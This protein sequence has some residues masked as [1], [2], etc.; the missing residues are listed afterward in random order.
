[1]NNI[2][3]NLMMKNSIKM[4]Y[5]FETIES[6]TKVNWWKYESRINGIN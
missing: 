6:S 3:E 1:M 2:Y 4:T 5:I